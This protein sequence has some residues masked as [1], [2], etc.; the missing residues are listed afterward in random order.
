MSVTQLSTEAQE[1]LT[2]AKLGGLKKKLIRNP[3]KI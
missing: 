1:D 3:W 2:S